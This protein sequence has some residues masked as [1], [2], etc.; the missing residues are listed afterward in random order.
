MPIEKLFT[1]VGTTKN[2]E[3]ETKMRWA[4]DLVLRINILIK[5]GCEE[6][7]LYETPRPMTKLEAANWLYDSR[8]LN[9]D[10]EEAVAFKIA[11][12]EKVN[13]RAQAKATITENV[14]TNVKKNKS[15]D[16]RVASF[17]ETVQR[18]AEA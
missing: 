3:G 15:A 1:V 18:E 10:Q 4:N 7:N 12:K 14:N 5:A 16:P 9:V 8:V 11:E 2:A 6:I 13:K 17:I